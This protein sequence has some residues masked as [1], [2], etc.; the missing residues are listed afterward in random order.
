MWW[1]HSDENKIGR[2]R[3]RDT[4]GHAS[5]SYLPSLPE[6]PVNI[7]HQKLLCVIHIF[8]VSDRAVANDSFSDCA[9]PELVRKKC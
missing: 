6:R 4:S 1:R 3:S 2:D 8:D 9:P 7:L 5:Y